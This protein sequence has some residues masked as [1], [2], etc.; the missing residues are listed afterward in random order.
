MEQ[1]TRASSDDGLLAL[2]KDERGRVQ[3][4]EIL[5]VP[6]KQKCTIPANSSSFEL[7]AIQQTT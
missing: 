1:L 7:L 2:Q 5:S 4:I 3:R 6:P